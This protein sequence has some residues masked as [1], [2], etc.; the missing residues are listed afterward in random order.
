MARRATRAIVRMVDDIYNNGIKISE[1]FV[2]E[3]SANEA[4]TKLAMAQEH[5]DKYITM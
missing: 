4:E 2:S 1:L 3:H 5:N